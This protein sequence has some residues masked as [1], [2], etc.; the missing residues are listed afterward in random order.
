MKTIVKTK[1]NINWAWSDCRINNLLE[2]VAT[3][4]YTASLEINNTSVRFLNIQ[5]ETSISFIYNNLSGK[6]MDKIIMN[7]HR[8]NTGTVLAKNQT[9]IVNTNYYI[10]NLKSEANQLFIDILYRSSQPKQKVYLEINCMNLLNNQIF[11]RLYNLEYA[12]IR[13]NFQL[14]P[15]QLVFIARFRF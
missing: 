3:R 15:R 7:L 13:N 1:G 6:T 2:N 8:L 10:T 12:I 9:I 5:Y 14:Q 4:D 11:V